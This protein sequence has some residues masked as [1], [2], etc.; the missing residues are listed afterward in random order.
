MSASIYAWVEV[1]V[2]RLEIKQFTNTLSKNKKAV[3]EER[4]EETKTGESVGRKRDGGY[5]VVNGRRKQC[6]ILQ[7]SS[8]CSIK[9][10][11][12]IY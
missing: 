2:E 9:M 8:N 1:L 11:I 12:D 10:T 5:Y 7:R 4:T 3:L 6:L